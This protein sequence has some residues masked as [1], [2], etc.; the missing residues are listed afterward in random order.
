MPNTPQNTQMNITDDIDKYVTQL[1]DEIDAK[2]LNK[3]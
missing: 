3:I 1:Y 2:I